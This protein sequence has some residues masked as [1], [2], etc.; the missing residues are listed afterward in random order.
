MINPNTIGINYRNFKPILQKYI[1]IET[2]F[3]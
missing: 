1:P 2:L 3:K